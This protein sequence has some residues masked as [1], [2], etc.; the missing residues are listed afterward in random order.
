MQAVIIMIISKHDKIVKGHNNFKLNLTSI[1]KSG[2]LSRQ[3]DNKTDRQK[4]AYL[5]IMI[6][7]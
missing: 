2:K 6:F 5:Y 1:K 3:L 4:A 7:R